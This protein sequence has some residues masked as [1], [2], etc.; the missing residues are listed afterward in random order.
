MHSDT[1]KLLLEMPKLSKT[2]QHHWNVMKLSE[3]YKEQNLKA[4]LFKNVVHTVYIYKSTMIH[5]IKFSRILQLRHKAPR[6]SVNNLIF[7]TKTK[8]GI[9][10]RSKWYKTV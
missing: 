8:Q 5:T 1:M 6:T 2:F 7:H 4:C 10:K 3:I 9:P